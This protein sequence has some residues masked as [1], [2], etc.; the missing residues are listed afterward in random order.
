MKIKLLLLVLIVPVMVAFADADSIVADRPGFSTGTA[1]VKPKTVNVELGYQYSF[2]N[3][4]LA[5]TSHM[6]PMTTVRTGISDNAELDLL[7][8]GF[9]VDKDKDYP[10]TS[11]GDIAIGG[12]YKLYQS[13]KYNITALGVLSLPT[14][15]YPSTSDSVDPLI[16]ILFDYSISNDDTLFGIIQAS[17]S[18]LEHNRVYDTRYALGNSVKHTD[19][20]GSFI[21]FYT[22]V[23]SE[24]TQYDTRGLDFGM[25]YLLTKDI[26]LDCSAGVALTKYS[27]NFIGF[28]IAFRF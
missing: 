13:E 7:W 16:G 8:N 11:K 22:I 20:I 6:F 28:G 1:T 2:N 27:S 18:Q 3:H 25:T 14:G 17:S 4:G 24:P 26:Q 21:E 15:T 12:K 19:T 5:N 23:Q 10:T 9:T